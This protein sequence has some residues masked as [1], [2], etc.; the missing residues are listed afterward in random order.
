MLEIE[1]LFQNQEQI[2]IKMLQNPA[3]RFDRNEGLN[4]DSM[5][6]APSAEQ[7]APQVSSRHDLVKHAG[8]KTQNTV[9]VWIE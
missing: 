4:R 8:G 2:K 7:R 6:N 9:R 1:R 3:P 5:L